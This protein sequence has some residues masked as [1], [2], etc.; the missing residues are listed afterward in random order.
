MLDYRGRRPDAAQQIFA[1]LEGTFRRWLL[2]SVL[3]ASMRID[4]QDVG[5]LVVPNRVNVCPSRRGRAKARP[6]VQKSLR[7]ATRISS[8]T[9][10]RR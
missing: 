8:R 10:E 4:G 2:G 3:A 5:E 6:S 1:G 7:S 9:G